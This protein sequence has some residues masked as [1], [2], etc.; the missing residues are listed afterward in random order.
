MVDGFGYRL[1][2]LVLFM[3]FVAV[4]P[5]PVISLLFSFETVKVAIPLVPLIQP[6]TEFDPRIN[7]LDLRLSKHFKLN[8]LRIK[9]NVD[10]YNATNAN[11]VVVANWTYSGNGATYLQPQ[12]ILDA[13]LFKFGVQVNF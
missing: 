7:Q 13:R 10:L 9:G 5:V 2:L 4:T 12:Q 8:R 6:A 3:F 11:P 1:V